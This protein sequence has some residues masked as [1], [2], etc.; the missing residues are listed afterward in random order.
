M[1]K[2]TE[3]LKSPIQVPEFG[4]SGQL[5]F[6]KEMSSQKDRIKGSVGGRLG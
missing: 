6:V 3:E 5:S 4:V 2:F 1:K